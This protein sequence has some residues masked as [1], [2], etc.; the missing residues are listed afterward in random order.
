MGLV[1]YL[2]PESDLDSRVAEITQIYLRAASEGQRQAK[3]LVNLAFDLDWDAF[4]E[5][6]LES[7]AAAL[8]SEQHQEAMLAYRESREPRF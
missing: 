4:L 6:Y 1:D 2:V 8:Q 5:K 7:Q 3:R